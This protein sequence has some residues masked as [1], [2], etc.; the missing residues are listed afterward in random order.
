MHSKFVLFDNLLCDWFEKAKNIRKIWWK[1]IP[2]GF[3]QFE[4]FDN[5]I[6]LKSVR[7]DWTQPLLIHQPAQID[8]YFVKVSTP[9]I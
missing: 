4:K 8:K 9:N 1:L 7:F 6:N 3:V 2:I 5:K